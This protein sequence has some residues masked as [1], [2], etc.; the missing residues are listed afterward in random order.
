[1]L[2]LTV[3][4]QFQLPEADYGGS[5]RFIGVLTAISNAVVGVKRIVEHIEEVI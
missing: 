4:L 2:Q 5:T 3:A 1:L